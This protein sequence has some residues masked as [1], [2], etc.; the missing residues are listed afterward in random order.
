MK[1]S[2]SNLALWAV[3][4]VYAIIYSSISL[5]NHYNF[6]TYAHDLGII[7]NSIYDYS[8]FRANDCTLM[9]R[10]FTNLLSDHFTLIPAIV[11]SLRYF[12]GTYSMLV[13]QIISILIGGIGIFCF[14][15]LKN[16]QVFSLIA[17]IHFLSCWGIYSA[18]SFDYHDN[19]VGAMAVPWLFYFFKKENRLLLGL[20]F[21]LILISKENVALWMAFIAFGMVLLNEK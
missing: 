7:N 18:L 19:V 17:M 15:R 13:V 6:R 21:I 4:I 8:Q 12:F 16:S 10:K 11:A 9:D 1:A 5:V 3:I 14:F 20:T 2:K